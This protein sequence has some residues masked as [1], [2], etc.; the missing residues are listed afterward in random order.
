MHNCIRCYRI[1]VNLC[2]IYF[3]YSTIYSLTYYLYS[4]FYIV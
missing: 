4:I 1:S 3:T 2:F